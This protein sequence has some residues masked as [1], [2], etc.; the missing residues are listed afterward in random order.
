MRLAV[1]TLFIGFSYTAYSQKY[2]DLVQLHYQKTGQNKFENSA[3]KT[4]I[5]ELSLNITLPLKINENTAII[6]GL[7]ADKYTADITGFGDKAT[8]SSYVL[9]AGVNT[10]HSDKWNAT[11]LL[12]PQLA[13]DFKGKNE[14]NFQ[15]GAAVLYSYKKHE[16][17]KYKLGFYYN[18]DKFGTFMVPLI[19]L[20]YKKNK[21]ETN[22]LLP[23]TADVNYSITNSL[24]FGMN[25]KA[26]VKSFNLAKPYLSTGNEYLEQKSSEALGYIGYKFKN[27]IILKAQ[28]GHSF[29][30]T[31]GIFK[32]KDKIDWTFGAI[33]PGEGP[34]QLNP[35]FADG[36]LFKVQMVYRFHLD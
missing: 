5:E 35:D 4:T 10:T 22:L 32:E 33:Q 14:G 15:L 26:T 23:H 29:G 16:N 28:I 9:K 31:Y 12:M 25:F 17:L 2:V 8:L 18:G 1:V 6:T 19:G 21:F 13:S 27:G 20:Y 24:Y 34:K 7:S 3:A 36:I 11:Y 30:R